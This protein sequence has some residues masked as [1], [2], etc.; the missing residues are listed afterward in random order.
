[1]VNDVNGVGPEGGHTFRFLWESRSSSKVVGDRLYSDAPGYTGGLRMFAVRGW[2]LRDALTMAAGLPFE[3]LMGEA[4]DYETTLRGLLTAA[5][6]LSRDRG[7]VAK[8]HAGGPHHYSDERLVDLLHE[9][10]REST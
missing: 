10:L 5:R 7:Y 8:D 1:M 6:D 3:V 9:L 2:S 4:D